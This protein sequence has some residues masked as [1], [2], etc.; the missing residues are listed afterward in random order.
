MRN[1]YGAGGSVEFF[2]GKSW[3]QVLE[4]QLKLLLNEF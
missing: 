1:D 2:S 3:Q 4:T